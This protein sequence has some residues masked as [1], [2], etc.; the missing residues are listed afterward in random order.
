MEN[1]PVPPGSD[2]GA[3][4]SPELARAWD[5]LRGVDDPEIGVN[6]VDVGLIYGIEVDA[7]RVHVR[8][9]MTSAAC[10][11]GE[12]LVEEAWSALARAFPGIADIDVELVWDPPWTP[13]RM[14]PDARAFFGWS[15]D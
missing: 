6:I 10:P 4:L 9:T 8:M 13:E 2:P 7:Q 3:A 14:S 5:A 11:M 1:A 15:P 12:D